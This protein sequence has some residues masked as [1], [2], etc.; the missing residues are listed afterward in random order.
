M[1]INIKNNSIKTITF[2]SALII[3]L[4]LYCSNPDWMWANST[5]GADYAQPN[6]IKNDKDGNSYLT[7]YYR[8]SITFDTINFAVSN[9]LSTIFFLA[10]YSSEGKIIWAKSAGTN[11]Y[12]SGNSIAIDNENN[13]YVTGYFDNYTITF[14]DIVLTNTKPGYSNIF[15][16]K[17]NSSGKAVWAKNVTG[18]GNCSGEAV[19]T[20]KEGNIYLAG[21]YDGKNLTIGSVTLTNTVSN[22]FN[23]DIYIAKFNSSGD[24]L[25]VKG[26]GSNSIDEA[27]KIAIDTNGSIYLSG[28]FQGAS[29][30]FNDTTITNNTYGKS[31]IFLA[32]YNNNGNIIWVKNAIG[33]KSEFLNGLYV[34]PNNNVYI[35]GDFNSPTLIFDSIS[36]TNTGSY[37][38]LFISK[39]D[40]NGKILWVK[41][42]GRYNDVSAS[43]LQGDSE[44]NIYITGWFS[45]N[46][47]S[48]GANSLTN[49]SFSNDIFVVKFDSAGNDIWVISPTVS[50]QV[51]YTAGISID[52]NNSCYITGQFNKSIV[53]KNSSVYN[54]TSLLEIF[55]AKLGDNSNTKNPT[56]DSNSLTVYPNPVIDK[57]HINL[58][59]NIDKAGKIKLFNIQGQL[60]IEQP[61]EKVVSE[62][63]F[64]QFKS[65][66]YILSVEN[67]NKQNNFRIIKY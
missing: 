31:E 34:D 42:A 49:D 66:I 14:D 28:V 13:I 21:N 24:V 29:L 36:I 48:F 5:G 6:C 33:S 51:I 26:A 20:D 12:Q 52:S 18:V 50:A 9:N 17:F 16:V 30:N 7:G 47:I 59:S 22:G 19:T 11:S 37:Y 45:D 58:N 55:I 10:K 40:T 62:L 23:S 53:F 57:L 2:F 65:G 1:K 4:N 41:R 39:Y 43:G 56:I 15:L 8:A 63:D 35:A 27:K 38:D 44:G 3:S 64:Y 46:S 67:N 25:W 32:K 61:L 54:N 60:L